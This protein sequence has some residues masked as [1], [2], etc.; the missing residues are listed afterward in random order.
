MKLFS[1]T[2]LL[3]FV[4]MSIIPFTLSGFNL[5]TTLDE[6]EIANDSSDFIY[7]VNVKCTEL[8]NNNIVVVSGFRYS[9]M[10]KA[11]IYSPDMK[12]IVVPEFQITDNLKADTY[13]PG[14][15]VET[16]S[17]GN[18]IVSWTYGG[19]VGFII[20]N[21][22]G[23]KLLND[24]IQKLIQPYEVTIII[25]LSGKYVAVFTHLEIEI[26]KVRIYAIIYDNSGS[27]AKS[28]FMINDMDRASGFINQPSVAAL[29]G[30]KW[31]VTWCDNVKI[32][33]QRGHL[34]W[35]DSSIDAFGVLY[36]SDGNIVK[37]TFRV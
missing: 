13:M 1:S 26:R 3:L 5:D 31:V 29:S 4:A 11:K 8:Q 15:T 6:F 37:P 14:F 20:F 16:L 10:V 35:Y 32:K 33:I 22:K 7:Y 30:D 12:S 27:V 24:D 18:F 9:G 2:N 21:S 17:N 34:E 23:E 19:G 36:D 28:I 25:P